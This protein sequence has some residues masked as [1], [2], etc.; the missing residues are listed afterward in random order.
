VDKAFQLF[1][2]MAYKRCIPDISTCNR[3]VISLCRVE[4]LEFALKVVEKMPIIGVDRDRLTLQTIVKALRDAGRSK[5]S[6][7]YL[8]QLVEK[9]AI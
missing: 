6:E 3:L 8:G 2:E 9:L 7:Q 1:N 5:E 4:K